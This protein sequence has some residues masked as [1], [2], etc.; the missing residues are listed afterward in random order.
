VS[1][2]FL[3]QSVCF[4]GV[5]FRRA[6]LAI[7]NPGA[8]HRLRRS[9][10][11]RDGEGRM[12]AASIQSR[13][14]SGGASRA[15]GSCVELGP[16]G[17]RLGR[18]GDV[19][20]QGQGYVLRKTW[21]TT[22]F[23]SQTTIH[24]DYPPLVPSAQALIFFWLNRFDDVASRVVFRCVL[25]VGRSHLVVVAGRVFGSARVACGC[26]GGAPCRC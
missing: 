10:R 21:P 20:A 14:F 25:R 17:L 3:R 15:V 8:D 6:V 13:R 18:V 5:S 16:T 1:A 4:L 22:L 7:P 24:P 23:D 26:C 2:A 19:G 9:W 11:G 12:V